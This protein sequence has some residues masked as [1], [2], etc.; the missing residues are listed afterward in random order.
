MQIK[1]NRGIYLCRYQRLTYMNESSSRKSFLGGI[2]SFGYGIKNT[3]GVVV[4]ELICHLYVQFLRIAIRE[5][6]RKTLS[7]E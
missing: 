4:V 7:R 6:P 2:F 3:F 1:F 5:D